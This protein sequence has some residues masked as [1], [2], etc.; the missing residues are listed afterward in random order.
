MPG[1]ATGGRWS[2]QVGSCWH[3][4]RGGARRAVHCLTVQAAE[5]TARGRRP[6]EVMRAFRVTQDGRGEDLACLPP[7]TPLQN[8]HYELV[9]LAGGG[10]EELVIAQVGWRARGGGVKGA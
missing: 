1:R 4:M 9:R 2:G 3:V 10:Q 7:A 6:A 8:Y 5:P